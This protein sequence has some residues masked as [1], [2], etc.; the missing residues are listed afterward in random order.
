MRIHLVV[1]SILAGALA[2]ALPQSVVAQNY[3]YAVG[4]PT[5]GVNVPI[6]NG[7]IN[8]ANGNVHLEIPIAS[9][10]QRGNLQLNERLVYDSRIWTIT[11]NL[12]WSPTN[13]PNSMAGWRFVNGLQGGSYTTTVL[14]YTNTQCSNGP[15]Q[16]NTDLGITYIDASGTSHPTSAVQVLETNVC[17]N[18]PN[19][20][21]L[22]GGYALDATGYYVSDDGTGNPL[23]RDN[24]GNEVYPKQIDRFGNYWSSDANLNLIDDLNR[25]PVITTTSGNTITYSVLAFGGGRVSYVVTTGPIPVATQFKQSGV[26]DESYTLTAIQSVKL[27]DGSSYSF[28]YDNGGYG[29]MTSMTLP[30][31]GVVQFGYINYFDSF[32]NANRW[33]TS[34]S[35]GL[36]SLTFAPS[37]ATQCT[38]SQKTGCVEQVK[39]TTA[40][41]GS[42]PGSDTV[43]KLTLNN[44]A[45]NTTTDRYQGPMGSNQKLTS[46][47]SVYNFSTPCPSGM[48]VGAAYVTKQNDVTTLSDVGYPTQTVYG[49]NNPLLGKITSLKQWEY[50]AGSPPSTPTLDT[51]FSYSDGYD[52]SQVQVLDGSGNPVSLTTYGFNSTASA[53]SAPASG[54]NASLGIGGPYLAS[55]GQWIN[56]TG[57][58]LT[59]TFTN[60]DAGMQLTSTD[61]NGQTTFS[62][63]SGDAYVTGV[64]PPT[65]SSGVT[66]SSSAKYD[67]STGLPLTTTDLNGA[68]TTYVSY[69]WAGRPLAINYPDGGQMTASYSAT[70]IGIEHLMNAST[71]TNT[72]T[73]LDGYGRTS[74][75]AVG[76][77]QSTNPYYQTDYCY[78]ANGRLQFKSYQYQGNGWATPMV[79][80]GAGDG[81]TYDGLGRVTG[82]AHGDGTSYAYKYTGRAVETTDESGVQRIVLSGAFGQPEYICEISSKAQLSTNPVNCGLD[83][84][85]TGF[86]TT[87]GYNLAGHST[88][89]V[90]GSQENATQQART[91]QTD[92][93]GRTIS[94]VEPESGTTNYS[95]QYSGV[96]GYGLYVSRTGSATTLNKQH[97]SLGRVVGVGSADGTVSQGFLYDKTDSQWS[98]GSG[99]K[100]LKGRL[101]EAWTG[102]GTG[103]LYSYDVMG[104]ITGLWQC[105]PSTCGTAAR[106]TR[107]LSFTYDYLGDVTSEGDQ[108][109]GT[110]NYT[111]SPA[112]EV[113]SITN[114]SYGGT[115]NPANLVSNVVNGPKGPL[116]WSLGNGHTP[117]SQYDSMGRLTGFWVCNGSIQPNCAGLGGPYGFVII[118]QGT[119][120]TNTQD[121][122]MGP[123]VMGY[124]DFNRLT[125]VNRYSGA[126]T[127]TNVYDLFGNRWQQNAPQGGST[128]N[129]SFNQAKNQISTS[130]YTYNAAGQLINDPFHSYTYDA[131]GNLLTVD[132][133]ATAQYVY[134]ALNHRVK[135]QDA[136]GTN[137]YLYD[138]LGK[139]IST[140]VASSNFGSEGRIYWG[141]QQLA[142]RSSDGTTYFDHQDWT[143]TERVRTNYAG[144]DAALYA[145]FAYGDD[146]Y[147]FDIL[148]ANS[149]YNQ[150][151]AFY[152]GL[153]YDSGSGT[154]HAMFRQYTPLQGRWMSPD[155]YSGSYD[156]ANPQTFNRYSYALNNPFAFTDPQGLDGDSPISIGNTVG[157]CVG[158]AI[159]EG[160]DPIS[161]IGCGLSIFEDILGLFGG[162]PSFHGTL[163]PR[164]STGNP[165]WD[166]NFGES[167]GIPTSI[168]QGNFGLAM[169]LGLPS[170][171]CEFGPCGGGGFGFGPGGAVSLSTGLQSVAGGLSQF[172]PA[173]LDPFDVH[174]KLFGT[175]WCGPGGGGD[176]TG[177]V[178]KACMA[179]DL[180]FKAAGISSLYNLG[181]QTNTPARRAAA[182]ACNQQLYNSVSL[183]PNETGSEPIQLWLLYGES[184]GILAPGTSVNPH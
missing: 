64:T 137:E 73:L 48:C 82:I 59:T 102:S 83:I 89:I 169:A 140:W 113:T 166:G 22:N 71:R 35:G 12:Q 139:R 75:V 78:D 118:P 141:G 104:R 180:C 149:G 177:H 157:G 136:N 69:D 66:L 130:G 43:Y 181:L 179:H 58:T 98:N 38:G 147:A 106:T 105:A 158:V 176:T 37:V 117:V 182:A 6:D 81:Y 116:S 29:E 101:A 121:T 161:D 133:G 11:S 143:G 68:Q 34:Y 36:G 54:H 175:H 53:S 14:G 115:Y 77:G 151:N 46:T 1:P 168:P 27:P 80:S 88:I 150:D 112:Q 155:R 178:D 50:Y 165:N 7:Y 19:K 39:M 107:P 99:A 94:V 44:G 110:I 51:E 153:D 79:C 25:T 160:G 125:S 63:D 16:A 61:P 134:D 93:L 8:V 142:F 144:S 162:H 122:V 148:N 62:H 28:F 15:V 23:V 13:V 184:Y 30:S 173:Y 170:Q 159:S 42:T 55:V 120:V 127:F 60:D 20:T 85:G 70:Q 74:R 108:V 56:N 172:F 24:N 84:A 45:W 67:P 5:F 114:A 156:P 135:T 49:F 119:R 87:Y 4:N 92:S 65:P 72:Q 128:L 2:I 90:Q 47:A 163:S 152:A 109:S 164:P 10:P 33:L 21:V 154:D 138:H 167:L 52:L 123:T 41:V 95:Y 9:H 145:S 97:D 96:A 103:S 31:G 40:T 17:N 146:S 91:F 86:L 183:F 111:Y 132:A 100:N 3:V 124:D 129:V 131:V 32:Q 174:H 57:N 26:T 18:Q 171:G 76:N 126:Q